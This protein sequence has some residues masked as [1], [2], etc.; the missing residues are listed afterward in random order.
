MGGAFQAAFK[1]GIPNSYKGCAAETMTYILRSVF[2][3]A[4]GIWTKLW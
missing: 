3:E 2:K 4:S 1:H